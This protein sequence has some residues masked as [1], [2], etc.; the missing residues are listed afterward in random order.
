MESSAKTSEGIKKL[1]V[2]VSRLLI[3]KEEGQQADNLISV[4]VRFE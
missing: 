3:K 1:F 2:A 4:D